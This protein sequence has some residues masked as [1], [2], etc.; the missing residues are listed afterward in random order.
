M[1]AEMV[2][3]MEDIV[4][5]VVIAGLMFR[6]LSIVLLVPE[7]LERVCVVGAMKTRDKQCISQDSQ[8]YICGCIQSFLPEEGECL[9]GL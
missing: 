3:C 6:G 8:L 9:T 5:G 7:L 1:I 4:V 2:A